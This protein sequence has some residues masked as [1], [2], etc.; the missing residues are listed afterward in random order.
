MPETINR[1]PYALNNA[2]NI[3][4]PSGLCG[5]CNWA[6]DRADDLKDEAE[7]F[8]DDVGNAVDRADRFL[9][10]HPEIVLGVQAVS[11]YGVQVTCWPPTNPVCYG[12]L[13]VYGGSTAL[14]YRYSGSRPERIATVAA[15]FVG[16]FRP[17][18]LTLLPNIGVC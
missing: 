18:G 2:V 1:Y 3:V 7:D 12:A 5:I 6:E 10:S 17:K 16:L 15:G 11:G 8:V 13:V 14:R 9:R 4:D